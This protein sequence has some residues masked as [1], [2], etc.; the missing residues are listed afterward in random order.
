LIEFRVEVDLGGWP[1]VV[2]RFAVS[3][4]WCVDGIAV[5]AVS[6]QDPEN[7]S[8]GACGGNSLLGRHEFTPVGLLNEVLARV[9]TLRR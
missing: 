3:M 6:A 1:V 2:R 4:S 9:S 8:A 7:G 5:A